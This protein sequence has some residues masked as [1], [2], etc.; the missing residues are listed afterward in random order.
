MISNRT[1]RIWSRLTR[2]K[3]LV[4][5]KMKNWKTE[6]SDLVGRQTP[7]RDR[8]LIENSMETGN[9]AIMKKVR[10][11]SWRASTEKK[12]WRKWAMK[13]V[14]M[15]FLKINLTRWDPKASKKN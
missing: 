3:I 12:K 10:K 2:K 8:N 14:S 9:W 7:I 4:K 11:K 6:R 15:K 5:M 13:V 1:K